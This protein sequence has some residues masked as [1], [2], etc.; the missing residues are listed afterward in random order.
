MG[1]TGGE[2]GGFVWLAGRPAL[3]L[4]NTRLGERELLARPAD[5]ARWL[6]EAGL[7]EGRLRARRGELDSARI[8]REGLRAA[9]LGDDGDALAA[10]AD[11][12]LHTAPGRLCVEP[13]TLEARF[14]P[15]ARTPCCALVAVVLDALAL[16]REHPRRVRECDAE[17]CPVVF[18]D[19]SRRGGR[20]WCDMSRC[21]AR[22][23]S[24]TYYHRHRAD[25]PPSPSP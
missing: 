18:L 1:Q 19:T 11:G 13:P 9:L 16:G 4:C 5:L 15:A 14:R 24:T 3:D 22:A 12:W 17:R 8:L 7:S 6:A 21:G 23:K 10:L 25:D 20:R 2:P